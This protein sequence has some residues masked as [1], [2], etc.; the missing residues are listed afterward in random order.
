MDKQKILDAVI[1]EVKKSLKSPYSAVF[2]SL[3]ELKI[4]QRGNEYEVLGY[5][6]SQNSYGAMLRTEF[7]YYVNANDNREIRSVSGGVGDE[8]LSVKLSNARKNLEEARRKGEE[9]KSNNA[10][11]SFMYIGIIVI[12]LIV[13][14]YVVS[15]EQQAICKKIKTNKGMQNFLLHTLI[16]IKKL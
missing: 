15:K 1:P 13:F 3:E 16:F 9:I 6:D 10:I 8:R 5:V 2:C 4:E 7:E 12:V 14:F 11:V